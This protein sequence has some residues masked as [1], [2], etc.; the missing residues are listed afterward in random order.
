MYTTKLIEHK[1]TNKHSTDEI[2]HLIN[3]IFSGNNYSSKNIDDHK[4]KVDHKKWMMPEEPQGFIK[5][6]NHDP[7]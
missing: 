6:K 2:D 5:C 7:L 4:I 1:K 3:K